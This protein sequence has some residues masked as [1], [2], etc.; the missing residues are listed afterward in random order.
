[1]KR[2]E[3]YTLLISL[4]F[5]ALSG[6]IFVHFVIYHQDKINKSGIVFND[7]ILDILPRGDFSYFIFGITYSSLLI[8]IFS[9]LKKLR[10]LS[11]FAVVYG[12]ILLTR[13][14]TLSLVP[15]REPVDLVSLN[16]PVLYDVIFSGEITADLFYS[17]HTAF[18]FS[19]YFLSKKPLYLVLGI[20]VG[21]LLMMQRVHYSID[22]VA[23]IPF[24]Y[25]IAK[26]VDRLFGKLMPKSGD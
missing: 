11:K 24:A 6:Q 4:V 21:F 12:V 2:K 20:T 9:R 19:M 13:T 25:L 26:L 22:I 17:G 8:F 15:L 3:L 18:V 14:I 23:A 5:L 1:M 16:D 7:F 10:E